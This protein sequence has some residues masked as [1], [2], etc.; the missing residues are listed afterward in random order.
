VRDD[1][2]DDE[3]VHRQQRQRPEG[4]D[5]PPRAIP[6]EEYNGLLDQTTGFWRDWLAQ[7]TYTG[8]WRES[9]NRSAVA[10][11]LMTYAPTGAL[12]A[13]PT[14]AARRTSPTDA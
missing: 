6:T 5:G 8:R 14:A 1:R 13:A 10:L 11:K 4:P 9:L 12:V 3:E 7:S 2:V